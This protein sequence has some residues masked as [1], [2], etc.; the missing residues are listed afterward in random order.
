[1]MGA[2]QPFISGAISKTINLP[3]EAMVEDIKSCYQMSWEL[4][5]K[6]NALYRDG[7]KLS[8][9][10]SNKSD[11]KEKE[12]DTISAVENA[13][14]QLASRNIEEL[15]QEQVL[16]AAQKIL[17][18]SQSTEFMRQ[19]SRIVERK[20]L[21]WK[22]RGFTQKAKVGGQTLFV[23]TGE[24]ND[25]T[26]GEI[27]ID[28]HREG[29]TFRSLMNCFSIAVSIGLQYGVPLEEYVSK[30]TFTRFE[31]SGIVEG[32]PNIKNATSIIDYIF[33]LL[34]F[35]YLNRSDL[36][37]IKPQ[38]TETVEKKVEAKK[39]SSKMILE[40]KPQPK[41]VSKAQNAAGSPIPVGVSG[42]ASDALPCAN[43]GSLS[44]IRNGTCLLCTNCGTTTGCS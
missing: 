36:V 34:G 33:R 3:N 8:Q 18:N 44:L 1:M 26:L 38:V 7:C 14:G 39:E 31:P 27:F 23:R 37:H 5:L 13:V 24:Y 19:L 32:H 16:Q 4:G 43:C 42:T 40:S 22:R 35:E 29:A 30:F 25:G 17:D 41:A 2:A 12:E 20:R 11:K 6:A 10:L 9:P 15:T 28:M 21:P